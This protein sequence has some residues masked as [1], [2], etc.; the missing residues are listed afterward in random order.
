LPEKPRCS[1]YGVQMEIYEPEVCALERQSEATVPPPGAV[2]FYG[3]SSIRLWTSLVDDFAGTPV[4][5]RGFGGSTLA[6]CSWFFWRLVRGLSARSIVLYAG[7]NDLADG[8]SPARV[9][10]QLKQLLHQVDLAFGPLPFAFISIK[11]SPARWHLLDGIQDV[12]RGARE[13]VESR[14]DG[15]FVNVAPHMVWRGQPRAEL[16]EPDGLHLSAA[17]YALWRELVL[18][19]RV[20]LFES[21]PQSRR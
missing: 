4:V 16:Y 2:V 17:G 1:D 7:D 6:A 3:S 14:D 20:P 15:V 5:N 10:E 19:H 21:G 18:E 11:P 13:L 8:E 12:N 9:L